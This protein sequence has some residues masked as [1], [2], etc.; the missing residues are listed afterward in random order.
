MV[1]APTRRASRNPLPIMVIGLGCAVLGYFFYRAPPAPNPYGRGEA[2]FAATMTETEVELLIRR[3][4]IDGQRRTPTWIEL[5]RTYRLRPRDLNRA[6]EIYNR[7]LPPGAPPA[8][9]NQ[10]IREGAVVVLPVE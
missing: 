10:R 9:P 6:M 1:D 3:V 7:Q 8:T 5:Q 2:P 4:D